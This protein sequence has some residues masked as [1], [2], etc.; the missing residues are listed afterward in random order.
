VSI[1]VLLSFF[2]FDVYPRLQIGSVLVHLAI[3]SQSS[4]SRR[5]VIQ[6]I[7]NAAAS[8]RQLVSLILREALTATLIKDKSVN[9]T[10]VREEAE[11]PVVD[12][13]RRY[14]ALILCCG[15]KEAATGENDDQLVDFI[16][17]AHHS[18]ICELSR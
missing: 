7:E 11:K 13:Q 1:I 4:E 6:T 16:V 18:T 17:L 5:M 10:P 8:L 14:A 2:H 3:H 9:S 15:N 12:M